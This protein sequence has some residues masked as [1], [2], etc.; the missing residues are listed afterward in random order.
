MEIEKH[1]EFPEERKGVIVNLESIAWHCNNL[2]CP[3][4]MEK[5]ASLVNGLA[6]EIADGKEGDQDTYRQLSNQ[7]SQ[8]I[9]RLQTNK[10][11]HQFT[12]DDINFY[13]DTS[14]AWRRKLQGATEAGHTHGGPA[15]AATPKGTGHHH[16]EVAEEEFEHPQ[17]TEKE[18]EKIVAQHHLVNEEEKELFE[19]CVADGG[20]VKQCRKSI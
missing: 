13:R 14:R 9:D 8:V 18:A 16:L 3:F 1:T 17:L 10:A 6:A 12:E 4:C 5:H 2:L 19:R 7:Y 11:T 20:S 15:E